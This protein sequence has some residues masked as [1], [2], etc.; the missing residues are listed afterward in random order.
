MRLLAYNQQ[1]VFN[2][3]GTLNK[4]TARR[5]FINK[6]CEIDFDMMDSLY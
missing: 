5:Q 4:D 2:A 1:S 3:M 6:I